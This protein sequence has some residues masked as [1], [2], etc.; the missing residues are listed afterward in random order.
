M[1]QVAEVDRPQHGPGE[2]LVEVAGAG[3]GP[4]DAKLR[5]GLFGPQPFPVVP[6]AELS[7]T[8]VAV[9]EGV[10]AVAVGDR[11]FGTNGFTGAYAEYACVAVAHLAPAP[12]SIELADAGAV[13]I[14]A[15]TALEGID[16]HLHLQSGERLLVAGASGGVGTFVVQIAAARGAH[17]IATASATNHE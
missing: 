10:D 14:G 11:I 5:A 15:G 13:P 7:G 16:D 17:V 9:G 2:V 3:V 6:G 4:W 8:I 1:L 12:A